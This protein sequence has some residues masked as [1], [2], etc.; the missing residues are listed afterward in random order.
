[1]KKTIALLMTA[2]L[3]CTLLTACSSR[4]TSALA[5]VKKAG[6]LTVATSPDFPPFESL[7]NGE[8]VGI[9]IDILQLICGKLGVELDIQQ[10]DFDS[11]LPGVQA[12]KFDL[13]ASGI[14][15]TDQRRKN[16][17]FTDAYCLAA[18]AIVVAEGSDVACKADLA[19]RKVSVQTGTTAETFCMEAGYDVNS[20]SANS[21]AQLALTGGKV[22]AWVIDDLTAADMVKIYNAEGGGQL[23]ILD[24]AMTSEPYAFAFAFGSEDLVKEINAILNG[25]VEDGTVASIFEKYEAPYT[26][27]AE[28]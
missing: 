6:K 27:P 17:L 24:E 4:E 19:G 3:L 28:S 5:K 14:S 12:G 26:S 11:V 1:M 20:Y 15:V 9:E 7:E 22:D 25:L 18:Q 2:L 16:V 21:D 13:G 23:V 8:V 10:M